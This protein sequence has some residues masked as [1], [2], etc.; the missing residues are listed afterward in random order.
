MYQTFLIK[1]AFQS[2]DWVEL[3]FWG[4]H[5]RNSVNVK[6]RGTKKIVVISQGTDDS[7]NLRRV[8]YIADCEPVNISGFAV[9]DIKLW[10]EEDGSLKAD[11]SSYSLKFTQS[12]TQT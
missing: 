1:I 4:L 3:E 7:K 11:Q 10:L 12:K 2:Y 6:S 9:L 5:D 8:L